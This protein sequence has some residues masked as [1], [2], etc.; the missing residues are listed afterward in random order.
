MEKK[1]KALTSNNL[2]NFIETSLKQKEGDN[3]TENFQHIIGD[4]SIGYNQQI[5]ITE[6]CVRLIKEKPELLIMLIESMLHLKN[7]AHFDVKYSLVEVL[8]IVIK[9]P[10]ASQSEMAEEFESFINEVKASLA[11]TSFSE[12]FLNKSCFLNM[13][14]FDN[15]DKQDISKL[16]AHLFSKGIEFI[17][18][19]TFSSSDFDFR[20]AWD[21]LKFIGEK[22]NQ[23]ITQQIERYQEQNSFEKV[24]SYI[25][26]VNNSTSNLQKSAYVQALFKLSLNDIIYVLNEVVIDNGS[27]GTNHDNGLDGLVSSILTYVNSMDNV[28]LKTTVFEH[29]IKRIYLHQNSIQECRKYPELIDLLTKDI[30]EFP[31]SFLSSVVLSGLPKYEDISAESILFFLKNYEAGN[32]VEIQRIVAE[33]SIEKKNELMNLPDIIQI[34]DRYSIFALKVQNLK[35]VDIEN[36]VP[37]IMSA[38]DERVQVIFQWINIEKINLTN[39]NHLN[40]ITD[41]MHKL[42]KSSSTTNIKHLFE[43][44]LVNENRDGLPSYFSK[45]LE[46]IFYK[47]FQSSPKV[48]FET[49]LRLSGPNGILQN[50]Y[51]EIRGDE[52]LSKSFKQNFKKECLEID[53]FK[54]DF[55]GRTIFDICNK[56]LDNSDSIFILDNIQ[57]SS[58]QIIQ[59][60]LS[61]LSEISKGHESL[62][63]KDLVLPFAAKFK[64]FT[65]LIELLPPELTHKES[66]YLLFKDLIAQHKNLFFSYEGKQLTSNLDKLIESELS[67]TIRH[68]NSNEIYFLDNYN[69]LEFLNLSISA[70][71]EKSLKSTKVVKRQTLKPDLFDSKHSE[72]ELI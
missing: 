4:I 21:K 38:P 53:V 52:K 65:K 36:I 58:I 2:I 44:E 29:L 45:Y 8:K 22:I 51:H 18:R 59:K 28:S 3:K 1:L 23:S 68:L 60:E 37:I 67:K 16:R 19:L 31:E 10:H 48:F 11:N 43:G 15:L 71:D 47:V 50:A 63:L 57:E 14:R 12:D 39:I 49:V 46:R 20:S 61:E 17:E 70:K 6:T 40:M 42:I 34:V 27:Y 62:K 33:L 25:N 35:L 54:N 7:V 64:S 69:P 55:A 41:V 72:L 32:R 26:S 5:R 30:S 24:I 9:R 66:N 13:F 56:V